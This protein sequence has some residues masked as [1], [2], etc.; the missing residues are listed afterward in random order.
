[1]FDPGGFD[2][3]D[4][5]FGFGLAVALGGLRRSRKPVSHAAVAS[6]NTKARIGLNGNRFGIMRSLPICN[7]TLHR[8]K[9]QA[10]RNLS[11]NIPVLRG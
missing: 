9:R 2:A 5:L 4:S 3:L 1:M 6:A 11:E 8:W 7:T 10:G